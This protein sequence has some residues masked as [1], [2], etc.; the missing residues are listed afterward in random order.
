MKVVIDIPKEEYESIKASVNKTSSDYRILNG[1]PLDDIKAEINA[2]ADLSAKTNDK[3]LFGG[4]EL[5]LG[6][7][8]KHTKGVSDGVSD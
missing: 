2:M 1:T 8:N 7:I 3:T 4:L 6:I 5:A